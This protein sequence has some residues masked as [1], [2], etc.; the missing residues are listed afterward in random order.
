MDGRANRPQLQRACSRCGAPILSAGR[1]LAYC[2][3]CRTP[4]RV[5]RWCG[6]TFRSQKPHE[7]CSRSCAA[8][9]RTRDAPHGA[10]HPSYRGVNRPYATYEWFQAR[11]AARSRDGWRCQDCGR[12]QSKAV[13]LNAHHLIARKDWGDRPGD[14]DGIVNL[15]TVCTGCHKRRHALPPAVLREHRREQGRAYYLAHRAERI[16]YAVEYQKGY[17]ARKREP[18]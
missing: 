3:T 14:P 8:R 5:C 17:R 10:A 18:A 1:S 11:D 6:K 16:A 9:H 12:P 2:E 15:V 13:R 4:E 7:T